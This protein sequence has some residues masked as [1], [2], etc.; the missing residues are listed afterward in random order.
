ML[1]TREKYDSEYAERKKQLHQEKKQVAEERESMLKKL[2]ESENELDKL[3][4]VNSAILA[5]VETAVATGKNKAS[6][7]LK[8]TL[9]KY[10]SE[11]RMSE[12]TSGI[13]Q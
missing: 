3:K 9:R 4:H 5:E 12:I 1:E 8:E 13:N 10:G 11:M 6:T 7:A 2:W